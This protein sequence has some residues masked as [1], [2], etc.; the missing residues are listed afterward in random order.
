MLTLYRCLLR[1]YPRAHREDFGEE[2]AAVFAAIQVERANQGRARRIRCCARESASLLAGALQEHLRTLG[3]RRI[4][5]GFAMRRFV[6]R[7]DFR[8]PKSTAVLM[9]IIFAGLVLA[10]EKGRAIAVSF[11]AGDSP[12]GSIQPAQHDF[13]VLVAVLLVFFYLAG[14]IGWAILFALRRDGVPRLSDITP[15]AE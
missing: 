2:M 1:L 4:W 14:L 7:A 8:F 12:A 13:L 9:M 15:E 5:E 11:S 10:I 6:M 3:M